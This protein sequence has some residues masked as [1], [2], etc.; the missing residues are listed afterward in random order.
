[1]LKIIMLRWEHRVKMYLKRLIMYVSF[2]LRLEN[3]SRLRYILRCFLK[4]MDKDMIFLVIPGTVI[5]VFFVI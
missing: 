5:A 3:Q 2:N 4:R 1:V